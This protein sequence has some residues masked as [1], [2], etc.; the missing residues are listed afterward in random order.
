MPRRRSTDKEGALQLSLNF[1]EAQEDSTQAIPQLSL[2]VSPQLNSQSKSLPLSSTTGRTIVFRE[3]KKDLRNQ[4][5]L[6]YLKT[7]QDWYRQSWGEV[8]YDAFP[9]EWIFHHLDPLLGKLQQRRARGSHW[10]TNYPLNVHRLEKDLTYLVAIAINEKVPLFFSFPV[11]PVSLGILTIAYYAHL[12]REER[13]PISRNHAV[14]SKSFVLWI[15]PHDNGQIQHLKISKSSKT[16]INL[17]E[18]LICIPAYRFEETAKDTRL[19]VVTARSLAEGIDLLQH[20]KYCSLVVLDDPSGQTCLSSFK[21]GS[22]VFELARNCQEKDLSMIGIIPPWAM[23]QI[24][25]RENSSQT[26]ILLW[27]IDSSALR[28]YPVLPSPYTRNETSHPIEESY[29]LLTKKCEFGTDAQIT[30]RTFSFNRDD[31]NRIAEGFQ[32]VLDLLVEISKQPEMRSTWIKGWE[33]WRDLTAPILPFHL[34]WEQFL[35]GS[36]KQL[37]AVVERYNNPQASVL[38]RT[39]NSLIQRFQKLTQ[40]PFS[41]AIEAL[42]SNTTIAVTDVAHVDALKFFL[43]ERSQSPQPKVVAIGDLRGQ[44]GEKLVIIGQPKARYRDIVQTTFFHQIDVLLWAVLAERA[45]YWWSGLEIDSRI[46]HAKT[47]RS[48]TGQDIGGRYDYSHCPKAVRVVHSGT[49][50]LYKSIDISKL[51]ETLSEVGE[52]SLD[53]GLADS[54]ATQLNAHYLVELD[55]RFK[56]RVSPNSEF[57]VLSRGQA[58]VVSVRDITAGTTVVLFEG[59]NRDE[60]FAQ[61]AGLLEESRDNML[62]QVQLEGWRTVV[63][64]R[65]EQLGT[66]AVSRQIFRSTGIDI[67]EDAIRRWMNGEDLLTL[68]HE[69]EHFFWFFPP[70]ARSSFEEFWRKANSLREKRRQLG[71]V[72]SACAQEGWKERNA[73][74]IVFQY[75]HVFITVGELREAMQ[76]LKVKSAPQFIQQK[77]EYPFNRLFRCGE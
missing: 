37:E 16:K 22:E 76:V 34:L 1:D 60:L 58:R 31:E 55:N 42:D 72:I 5:A 70:V 21:Y 11:S 13:D 49:T 44:S 28:S 26:G 33:I 35:Q 2:Q 51:E 65:I 67:G 77:P 45:E 59:M 56:I 41:Q 24:E 8:F 46:W 71:R 62:Y 15:R 7:L 66:W 50:K 61:K 63:K 25:Y 14:A 23:Q 17:N 47:W 57:L 30:I 40:N 18:Q 69:K 36:L 10:S 54:N 4:Y 74:E 9:L 68:P 53:S 52:T 6:D 39:L 19:R 43:A 48:L 27:P 3:A 20:S 12:P 64:Q 75:Q 38:F 73:D 32:E 29:R